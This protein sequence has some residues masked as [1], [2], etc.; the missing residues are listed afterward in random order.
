MSTSAASPAAATARRQSILGIRLYA[1]LECEVEVL[2]VLLDGRSH[3]CAEQGIQETAN[4]LD[5]GDEHRAV[6]LQIQVERAGSRKEPVCADVA[7][8]A[9]LSRRYQLGQYCLDLG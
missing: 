7:V 8:P 1:P 6:G 4:V 9:E 3:H 2:V 5:V